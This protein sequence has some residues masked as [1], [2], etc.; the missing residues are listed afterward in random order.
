MTPTPRTDA[1]QHEGLIRGSA[2][3]TKVIRADFARQLEREN[4]ELLERLNERTQSHIHAS[5]RDV[6]TIQQQAVEL[7]KW[8]AEA[9]QL[10]AER[11]HNANMAGMWRALAGGLASRLNLWHNAAGN[12]CNVQDAAALAAYEAAKA[13]GPAAKV[14]DWKM[15][16]D[17][18]WDTSC[19]QCMSFEYAPPVE[20][21]YKFC[22]HCGLPINFIKFIKPLDESLD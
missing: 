3:P 19:K 22:H 4:A 14:C 21:G 15:D 17:G 20:Q 6:Q 12:R 16:Y 5:S 1:A 18:N 11:E 8:Q 7:A 10:S 13:G 2:T 9:A